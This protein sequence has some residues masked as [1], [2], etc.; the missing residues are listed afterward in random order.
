MKIRTGFVS[1]SSSSSFVI[2]GERIEQFKITKEMIK[3]GKIYIESY[4]GWDGCDFFQITKEMFELCEKYD[5]SDIDDFWTVEHLINADGGAE[6]SKDN[7][8]KNIFKIYTL[9]ISQH[10]TF[11]LKGFIDTYLPEIKEDY[12]SPQA[13]ELFAHFKEKEDFKKELNVMGYDVIKTKEGQKLK[14]RLK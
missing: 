7:I 8:L 13:K 1:N 12:I 4:R 2:I 6:I 14:K 5:V 9:N 11:N 3:E 10:H